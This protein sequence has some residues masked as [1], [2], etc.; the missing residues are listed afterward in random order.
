MPPPG[1]KHPCQLH[2]DALWLL[3]CAGQALRTVPGLSAIEDE[4]L[5][6]A[7]AAGHRAL[8]MATTARYIRKRT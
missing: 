3:I 1:R 5:A 8:L 2:A 7:V 6:E 4:R